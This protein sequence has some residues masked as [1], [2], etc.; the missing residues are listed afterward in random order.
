MT[1]TSSI[2]GTG[3]DYV[4][5]AIM[6]FLALIAAVAA[7]TRKGGLSKSEA[8]DIMTQAADRQAAELEQ[9][10]HTVQLLEDKLAEAAAFQDEKLGR[11]VEELQG[12]INSAL[13]QIQSGVERTSIE[14][15]D[16]ILQLARQQ[17]EAKAQSAI[18]M[19]DAL[20]T[21]LGSVRN[22]IA[23]QIAEP[24]TAEM[25]PDD[26]PQAAATRS[27]DDIQS[28]P[29]P[30]KLPPEL[31]KAGNEQASEDSDPSGHA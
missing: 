7:V 3:L 14:L 13:A 21:S 31:P 23:A 16:S 4:V 25:L 30:P 22:S 15:K 29:H 8:E 10:K 28:E 9:M 5:I 17:S 26:S 18:Q 20:I 1:D 27:E 2:A 24:R 6:I 19:C 12:S 11:S